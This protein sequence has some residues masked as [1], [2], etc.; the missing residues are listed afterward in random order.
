MPTATDS[1]ELPPGNVLQVGRWAIRFSRS[2]TVTVTGVDGT[3]P[4]FKRLK[5]T[6]YV[7]TPDEAAA[8]D[9]QPPIGLG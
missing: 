1:T 9:K 4:K 5:R 7:L 6:L 3:C 8:L 2:G